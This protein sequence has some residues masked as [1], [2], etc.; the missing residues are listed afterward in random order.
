MLSNVHFILAKQQSIALIKEAGKDDVIFLHFPRER[1][2][3]PAAHRA[4]LFCVCSYRLERLLAPKQPQLEEKCEAQDKA[5]YC[6]LV[7]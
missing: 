7:S 3:V 1:R 5:W 6:E 4:A 2:Q